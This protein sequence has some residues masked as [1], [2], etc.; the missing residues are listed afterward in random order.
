[1]EQDQRQESR[2]DQ[3]KQYKFEGKPLVKRATAYAS[4]EDSRGFVLVVRDRA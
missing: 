4:M 1:M 3:D 2:G